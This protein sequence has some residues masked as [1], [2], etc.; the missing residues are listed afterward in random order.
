[1]FHPDTIGQPLPMKNVHF[2]IILANILVLSG[3]CDRH[4]YQ[5]VPN[6]MVIPALREQHDAV[7]NIAASKYNGFEFQAVYS[8]LKYTAVMYDF[9]NIP[10]RSLDIPAWGREQIQEVG[11]G[12]YCGKDPWVFHFFGGYG[13]GFAECG[14]GI[15]FGNPDQYSVSRLDFEQW[16]IQPGVVMQTRRLRFG[17]AMRQVWLRH[18][19]G[20]VE[21]SNIPSHELNA[22]RGIEQG[23]P[24]SFTEFGFTL[25]FRFRPFTISY[26][27]VNIFDNQSRYYDLRF[28]TDNYNFM[29]TFDLYELWRGKDTKSGKGKKG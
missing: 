24:F 12:A 5:Y 4:F 8:P 27:S 23:T 13:G 17:V 19:N 15:D 20:S 16:F 18:Y 26:N 14:Y 22:I 11:I 1:V 7:I 3:G 21:V 29:L 9:I 10:Q 25:G 2:L 28:A 6:N